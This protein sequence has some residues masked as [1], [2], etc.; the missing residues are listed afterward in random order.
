MIKAVHN[1]LFGKQLSEEEVK[2]EVKYLIQSDPELA[3]ISS[4][5]SIP[6]TVKECDKGIRAYFDIQK[7]R[8][9]L[10]PFGYT[11]G[12]L[13][14]ALLH[15]LIHA[16]DQNILKIKINTLEGLA[17]S[18]VHAMKYCECRNNLFRRRDTFRNAVEAVNHSIHNEEQAY[19]AVNS[20]FNQA[21]SDNYPFLDQNSCSSKFIDSYSFDFDFDLNPYD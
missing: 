12:S 14:E 21:Y 6:I 4:K 18:E 13:Q 7:N 20:V 15:E 16:Y 3:N 1:F 17:K 2:N 11:S 9:V 8:I 10:S 5:I 19:N